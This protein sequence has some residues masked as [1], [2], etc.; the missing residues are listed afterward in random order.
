MELG[1][2]E[3]ALLLLTQ[4]GDPA[5]RSRSSGKLI[6]RKIPVAIPVYMTLQVA[7]VV[8]L[9]GGTEEDFRKVLADIEEQMTD[10]VTDVDVSNGKQE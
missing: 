3:V 8:S 6:D 10:A 2:T 1:A 9:V 5:E 4:N 7:P